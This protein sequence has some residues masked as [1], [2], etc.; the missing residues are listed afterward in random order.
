MVQYDSRIYILL[1]SYT[2]KE[3]N[4]VH[5]GCRKKSTINL[6][7][8]GCWYIAGQDCDLTLKQ[9]GFMVEIDY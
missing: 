2:Q 9:I 3:H 8:I 1:P 6:I 4:M 5:I 7:T